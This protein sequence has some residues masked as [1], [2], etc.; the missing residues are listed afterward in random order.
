[1]VTIPNHVLS[2]QALRRSVRS[3]ECCAQIPLPQVF[4]QAE[5]SLKKLP[6][7]RTEQASARE[8]TIYLQTPKLEDKHCFYVP[9]GLKKNDPGLD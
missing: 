3:H 7:P 8:T 6:L 5:A 1:M 9:R 4:G 2:D